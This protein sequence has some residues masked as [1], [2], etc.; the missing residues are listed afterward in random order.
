MDDLMYRFWGWFRDD[1][2]VERG[3]GGL[4]SSESM[5][6]NLSSNTTVTSD[7]TGNILNRVTYEF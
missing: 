3:M 6:S 5:A 2:D 7:I 1:L 4:S